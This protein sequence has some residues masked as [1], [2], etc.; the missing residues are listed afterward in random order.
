MRHT[1]SRSRADSKG[2][3][4]RRAP[5]AR[6]R[7]LPNSRVNSVTMLLVSLNSIA[8]STMALAFSL[9]MARSARRFGQKGKPW[10]PHAC[11][12]VL[13]SRLG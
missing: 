10:R 8:R 13:V 12:W 2:L 4:G 9:D 11:G 5:L 1:A 7:T 3:L 6:P